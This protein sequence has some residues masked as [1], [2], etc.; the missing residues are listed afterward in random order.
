MRSSNGLLIL[1]A[2]LVGC[3]SPGA[4]DFTPTTADASRK[5]AAVPDDSPFEQ[6]ATRLAASEEEAAAH[7]EFAESANVTTALNVPKTAESKSKDIEG[8]DVIATVNGAPIFASDVLAPYEAK[9]EQFRDQA[10]PAEY[11]KLVASLIRRDL[12]QQV[13]RQLLVE[14]MR[15]TLDKEQME[16]LDEQLERLFADETKRLQRQYGVHTKIELEQKLQELG[17]SLDKHNDNMAKQAMAMQY[18]QTKARASTHISRQEMLD[19]YREHQD[20]FRK[21]GRV[22]WQQIQVS[23]SKH[24]GKTESLETLDKAVEQLRQGKSFEEVAR[25]Y[26]DGPTATDGGTWEW[27]DVGSFA[28]GRIER[29]LF[30]LPVGTISQVLADDNTFQIVRAA[31]REDGGPTPF[32]DVQEAIKRA[33]RK[34]ADAEATQRVLAELRKTAIIETVFEDEGPAK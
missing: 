10:P 21:T 12:N 14:A 27:T 32:E 22:K 3:R 5:H 13:E 29:A 9:L 2:L 17:T 16:G 1:A 24:G 18:L 20:A 26:S 30:E 23:H 6:P 7:P 28:D 4:S 8:T 19:Y 31:E 11:R 33:L 25:Q 34:K 15:A